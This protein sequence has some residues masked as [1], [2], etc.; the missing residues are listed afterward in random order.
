MSAAPKGHTPVH[1][2]AITRPGQAW[3]PRHNIW[4]IALSVT[5]ATFMEVLDTSIANV[6]LPHI[7]GSLG[8]TQHEST[9]VLTSYLVSNAIVLPIS[10]WLSTVFGRKRFYMLCVMLFTVSSILCGMAT[11][12]SMLIVFRVLQGAG[13][14]GLGPSEQGILADTF[15]PRQRGMAFAIYGMAVILAPAIGPALGGWITDHYNWRWLFFINIPAGILSLML[16]YRMID[17]PPYLVRARK[18]TRRRGLN[19]DFMGLLLV[20]TFLGPLQILLDRG[21]EADWFQSHLIL[22]LGIVAAGSFIALI[23]WEWVHKRPVVDLRLFRHRTFALAT[24][25]MFVLGFVLYGSIVLLPQYV[26]VV[27]GWSAAQ[28]GMVL[29][30]GGVTLM[31]LMP[32]VGLMV[33][34]VDARWLIAIGFVLSALALYHMTIIDQQIDF[35]TA[36]MLRVYT[37]CGLAFL[38]VPLNTIA[39]TGIPAEKNDDV[40]SMINLA[41]N[42]G[43][44][45]GI[46]LSSTIV[47]R[48]MQLHHHDLAMHATNYD[49]RLREFS[50]QVQGLLHLHGLSHSNALD[51]TYAR[52]YLGL[53]GQATTMGYIDAFYVMAVISALMVPLVFLMKRSD[54]GRGM[55][56]G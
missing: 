4:A 26:Q 54:P 30:P 43:G 7:A 5:I 37:A 39:Y 53:N 48:R 45:V 12:L 44:S 19:L 15:P 50:G 17:D 20:A 16:T 3:T 1:R 49:L 6:A 40:S 13:G 56:I 41:R 33:S 23:W 52:I 34:R 22:A 27:L 21:E 38:F 36:M 25:L 11:S 46:A 9:W 28:A 10:A 47:A 51:Q 18:A 14:G 31:L 2:H 32:V 24:M 55:V 35:R 29:S 42:I 8:A